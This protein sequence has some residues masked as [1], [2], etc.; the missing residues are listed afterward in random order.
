MSGHG[1]GN[2]NVG[3]VKQFDAAERLWS[4]ADDREA[5]T[6][7]LDNFSSDVGIVREN[8]V[9]QQI[10]D[11]GDRVFFGD[12]AFFGKEAAAKDR[13]HFECGEKIR[14]YEVAIDIFGL[15]AGS[16]GG[17]VHARRNLL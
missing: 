13:L 8:A 10:A 1:C 9:P 12:L 11:H 7:E 4:D 16:G 6:I 15:T 3:P 5:V 14:R 17:G 2:E